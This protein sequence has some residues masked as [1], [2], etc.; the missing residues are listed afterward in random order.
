MSDP[1]SKK[2]EEPGTATS[3]VADELVRMILG[4]MV[5]AQACR[6]KPNSQST[7]A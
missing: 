5:P 1:V 2:R 7:T 3:N 4:R 6:A